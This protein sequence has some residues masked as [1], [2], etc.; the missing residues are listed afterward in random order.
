MKV[1]V[2]KPKKEKGKENEKGGN[3]QNHMDD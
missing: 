2:K 1:T 3:Q